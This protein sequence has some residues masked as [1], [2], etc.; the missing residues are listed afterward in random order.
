M[1]VYYPTYYMP[2]YQINGHKIDLSFVN[3]WLQ[4]AKVV[5]DN[6]HT[7]SLMVYYRKIS[8]CKMLQLVNQI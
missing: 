6:S 1:T 4:S 7:S 3:M 5:S 2:I 8:D